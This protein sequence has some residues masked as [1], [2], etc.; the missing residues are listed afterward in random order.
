MTRVTRLFNLKTT[1]LTK[2]EVKYISLHMITALIG[3]AFLRG[4]RVRPTPR[5]FRSV[6]ESM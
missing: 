1:R 5:T 4:G 2:D 3:E 6:V